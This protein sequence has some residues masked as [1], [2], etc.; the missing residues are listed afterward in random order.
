MPIWLLIGDDIS[1]Q[2]LEWSSAVISLGIDLDSQ[3]KADWQ[4]NTQTNK[5]WKNTSHLDFELNDMY[6]LF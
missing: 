5:K 2:Y 1:D 6:F 3:T 4:I